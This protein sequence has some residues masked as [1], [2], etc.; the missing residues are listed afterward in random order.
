[1]IQVAREVITG[2]KGPVEAA[3]DYNIPRINV[4][5]WVKRYKSEVMQRQTQEAL[6]LPIMRDTNPN[7][8][9]ADAEKRLQVLEEENLQLRKKLLESNLKAEALTTLIDLAEENYG[10]SLRKN[11]GAK[12][13]S[14]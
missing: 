8:K 10:I 2:I 7:K 3:R 4:F 14:E 6:T 12:Q 11:S 1:M 13:S 9:E 5:R